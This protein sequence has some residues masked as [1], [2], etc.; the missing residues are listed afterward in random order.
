MNKRISPQS[1]QSF[2]EKS[3]NLFASDAKIQDSQRITKKT[4]HKEHKEYFTT[5]RTEDTEFSIGLRR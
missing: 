1:T 3:G 5:E 4:I 2:A